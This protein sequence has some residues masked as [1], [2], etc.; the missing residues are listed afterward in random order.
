MRRKKRTASWGAEAGLACLRGTMLERAWAMLRSHVA[1]PEKSPDTGE[2]ENQA[3]VTPCSV[4]G[5]GD[6]M[7]VFEKENGTLEIV[8]NLHTERV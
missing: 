5:D 6:P 3:N 2:S 8:G 1:A 4:T 7:M